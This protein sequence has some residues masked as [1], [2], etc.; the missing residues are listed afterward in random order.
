MTL[1]LVVWIGGLRIL[2]EVKWEA[3]T[4]GTPPNHQ[5]N[6]VQTTNSPRGKLRKHG[7]PQALF[8]GQ[9]TVRTRFTAVMLRRVFWQPPKKNLGY[10]STRI[11]NIFSVYLWDGARQTTRQKEAGG[12]SLF[13]MRNPSIGGGDRASRLEGEATLANC[14]G[15]S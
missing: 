14:C 2:I 5:S 8:P 15:L 4:P 12:C 6:L 9:L 11:N 3:N 10:T 13:L 1:K 7:F